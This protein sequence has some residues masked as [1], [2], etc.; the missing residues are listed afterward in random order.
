MLKSECCFHIA[1]CVSDV[2]KP[3]LSRMLLYK[4]D[5]ELSRCFHKLC[6]S[7]HARTMMIQPLQY[8]LILCCL[9]F[10]RHLTV[11]TI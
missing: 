7:D 10:T 6:S 2:H 5:R 9:F 8:L 11:V 4:D 3:C 1:C